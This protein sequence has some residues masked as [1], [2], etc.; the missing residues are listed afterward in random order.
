MPRKTQKVLDSEMDKLEAVGAEGKKGIAA[1]KQI[2]SQ[3]EKDAKLAQEIEIE[4]LEQNK[5]KY[6][7]NIF[8]A[9]A[10]QKR[11]DDIDFPDEWKIKVAP[12]DRGVVMEIE[13]P[14]PRYFRS[15]F[16]ATGD[17]YYDLNAVNMFALRADNLIDNMP[18]QKTKG[19]ILLPN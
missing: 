7:Y 9:L 15:A 13:T 17:G 11:L 5:K 3:E 1:A 19:G 8:L 6:S 16:A 10:L 18:L 12:T 2:F 4:R 14:G